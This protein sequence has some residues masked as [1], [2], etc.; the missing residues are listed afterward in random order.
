MLCHKAQESHSRAPRGWAD[1]SIRIGKE[2]VSCQS[3][4]FSYVSILAATRLTV[5]LDSSTLGYQPSHVRP[6]SLATFPNESH[7]IHEASDVWHHL[8][9]SVT[10]VLG[11]PMETFPFFWHKPR[12]KTFVCVRVRVCVHPPV[13]VCPPVCVLGVKGRQRG[14]IH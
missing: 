6:K 13:C 2:G 4:F 14:T 5:Q 10:A 12:R 1:Q 3:C 9:V 11:Q 7:G 8:S